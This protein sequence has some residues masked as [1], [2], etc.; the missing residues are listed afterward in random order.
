MLRYIANRVLQTLPVLIGVS[1]LTFLLV[2]VVGGNPAVILLGPHATRA[3]VTALDKQFGLD[4]PLVEQYLS[5]IRGASV[6]SFGN[7]IVDRIPVRGLILG[8]AAVTVWLLAYSVVI[9]LFVAVPLAFISAIKRNR[10]ADHFVRLVTMVTFAMP[11]FWLGLLLV[12]LFGLQLNW[13]PTGGYQAGVIGHVRSLTLPAV[14]IGLYL[15]P[16]LVRT[17][18]SSVLE[19]MSQ[20]YI[21][22]ARARGVRELPLMT[23]HVFKNAVPATLSV[24]GVQIGFLFAGAVVVEEVFALPGIGSLLVNSVIARDFP[25][26]EALTLVF[27]VAV[28]LVNLFT[29]LLFAMLDPRIRL[30]GK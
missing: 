25:V 2:H 11:A 1:L 12:L 23:K 10:A 28:V 24:L 21:E 7:S 8:R 20:E 14:T 15:A 18:R 5:F 27:S 26:I 17:L 9:S 19:V 29:D 3:A 13:L 4:K 30:S 16:I 22:A 6:L